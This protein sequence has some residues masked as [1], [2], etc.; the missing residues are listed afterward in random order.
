MRS[1][2]ALQSAGWAGGARRRGQSS[3]HGLLL[4]CAAGD[5]D[6]AARLPN[7]P[8]AHRQSSPRRGRGHEGPRGELDGLRCQRHHLR[9]RLLRGAWFVV[10]NAGVATDAKNLSPGST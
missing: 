7:G 1:D 5:Q 2:M 4:V 6:D 9:A 3:R 10:G 8:D